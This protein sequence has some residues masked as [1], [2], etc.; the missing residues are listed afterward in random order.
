[1]VGAS[2]FQPRIISSF[3]GDR[4]VQSKQ[5]L[6]QL[7][8]YHPGCKHVSMQLPRRLSGLTNLLFNR[9]SDLE[10][11]PNSQRKRLRPGKISPRR[12]VPN[13]IQ[14]P[15][16]VKTRMA[17]GIASG[18]EV[19]DLKG[20]EC[21]R[22]SGR[23]AAQVL[24]YAGTL[25]KPG[26]TTDEIDQAVHQMIID[27][28]AYPSPLGYGGF[29]KSV[30][31]SVNECICHGIPDSRPLED[32]D[33]INI[34]VT[35]YLN[36]YHGDT[37]AT[38]FCGDVDEEAR[39]L[40]KVT[41]ECLDKAISICRPGVEFK[42]IGKTIHD[43]A[44]KF[45]YGVVRQFVGH[46][47]GRVFHADPVVLHFRNNDGGRMVLN[48]TFTIEP[49]L[50]IGSIN[51]VM[52]DDNWTVVTKDGSLLGVLPSSYGQRITVLSID[53]G[54]IRGIIPATILS[55]LELK[56]QELDGENAR[57]ADYFDVIAG[58]STG[59]LITAMLTTPD[60]NGRPLYMGKDI[61]PFYLK[62][63]PNIFPRSNYR[64][65]IMKIITLIRPKYNG[66][67][68]RKIICK[69]LGN[70]R[71]HETLTRVVIPTFD[72]KLLQPTVFSTFEAKIDTSKDAL[73][74]DI[75]ISTSSAPTYFPAYRFKTKDSEGN[76]REFHLVDGGIAANNPALL[77]LKPTG[78]AFPGDQEGSLGRAL[79]Y[80]NYLI[81]SL[82]TGTSKMEKK[83]NAKMA[84]KWGILGWLYREGSS[85]LVDA[86]TSAGADMVDLHMSLIFRS[87][88][89]E[90]NYLRIQDDRLSG[91]ASS[92]DKATQ[93]NMKNLVE[94][95]ERL[96]QKPVSRMN[97]DSGIFEPFEKEGTNQEALSRFAKLL[98]EERKLRWA[99]IEK[100]LGNN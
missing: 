16:Y 47:I 15:P 71:L 40:V 41:K 29:P 39:N 8:G 80:E 69:V 54:G 35:V 26:I 60:E 42:K 23:L 84:A 48:Q 67:Y 98:S 93:K 56:L 5:P 74:S 6:S 3:V 99:E 37:S 66:K 44:D 1:M 46:G 70:R 63:C 38:F 43:H 22:A 19:H 55:Y 10:E 90:Q 14:R 58:T 52:W 73:L 81:I 68:L 64:R 27:N 83:Y 97:L 25:V 86:F 24:N 2:S 17:P 31:T 50:T 34:D 4:L 18:P 61:A 57:I 59:G 88:N 20:I 76:D 75:C 92:T 100:Q 32:G 12:P 21:M 51:S 11:V 82:G 79:N 30:C 72:I 95:G 89:C 7:F 28:G 85:P 62:H 94:I 65:M 53:G 96:L 36:G 49:M 78:T 9:R 33:I 45:R 77:A 13:H 87:I 91:D